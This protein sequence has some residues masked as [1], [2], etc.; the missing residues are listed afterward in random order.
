VFPVQRLNSPSPHPH[1]TSRRSFL[2]SL[3]AFAAATCAPATFADARASTEA[4][5]VPWSAGTETPRTKAPPNTT[6][7]HHHIYDLRFPVDP[8]AVLKPG[9]A[10]VADYHLLEK[11]IGI[12]RHVIVQP[13]TY[14]VDNRCLL[15]ALHQFGLNNTRGVAVVNT[16]VSDAELKRLDAA[17]VRGIRFNLQQAG[18]TTLD[19]VEPLA[20]RIAPLGWHVQVNAAPAQIVAAAP[21]WNRLPV[22][23]VFDHLGHV[24]DAAADPAFGVIGKLL[25]GRKAWVKLSGIYI[26]SRIGPPSYADSSVVAKAYVKEAPERLVW[27]TDWPHPTAPAKPDDA[28]LFDLLAQWAPNAAT[29]TRILVDNPAALYSFSDAKRK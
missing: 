29:R 13:S 11:R 17:G 22:S 10:T 6:D 24:L 23:L 7:C 21:L 5:E 9:N 15:D 2:A 26:D 8:K 25:Q 1:E 14:G 16:T 12:T 3:S 28:L 19:M 18:A 4:L 27:G 20:K